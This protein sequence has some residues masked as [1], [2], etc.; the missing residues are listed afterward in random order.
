MCQKQGLEMLSVSCVTPKGII[1]NCES[2]ANQPEMLAIRQ[3]AKRLAT[4]YRKTV[5]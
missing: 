3:L 4:G 1:V 5:V 2:A